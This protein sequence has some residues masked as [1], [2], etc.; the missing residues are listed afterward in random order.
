MPFLSLGLVDDD[1]RE[2]TL[3]QG[4]S[5]AAMDEAKGSALP[6]EL[7]A[8]RQKLTDKDPV[9]IKTAPLSASVD[10]LSPAERAYVP[11]FSTFKFGYFPTRGMLYSTI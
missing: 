11:T 5:D 8:L 3:R 2:T 9:R 1:K 10:G 6:P 4:P 7:E